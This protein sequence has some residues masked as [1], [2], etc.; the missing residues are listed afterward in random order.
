MLTN[1]DSGTVGSPSTYDAALSVASISGVKSRYIIANGEQVLFYKESNSVTA[2]PNDFMNELVNSLP[3]EQQ[4]KYRNGEKLTFEYVTIPGVGKEVNYANV[5]DITGKIA[6][7]RRGD[8]SFEE[9]AMIAKNKGAIACIIYNNIDGDI[10]MSMGKTEHIPTIS[11]SKDDGTILASKIQVR[12]QYV[13]HIKQ[14]HL[15]LISQVGVLLL[16]LELNQKLLLM[17][18]KLCLLF[19]V[20]AMTN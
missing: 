13:Q 10:L 7:V 3:L 2:K 12:L 18:A 17:V 11:I 20:V 15:C 4:E 5:G 19:L 1:P 9:K 8:N 14:V 16:H 6:L